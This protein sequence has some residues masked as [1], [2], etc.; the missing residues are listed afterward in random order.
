MNPEGLP[1]R[2]KIL[3]TH[4][5]NGLIIGGSYVLIA[6]GLTLIFGILDAIN[7]AHGEVYMLGAYVLYFLFGVW[8]LNYWAALILAT[9]II[10]IFGI[11]IEKLS[12][13]PLRNQ[14]LLNTMLVSIALAI[15]LQNLAM[16]FWGADP[17]VVK[18]AMSEEV[19]QVFGVF[20]TVQRLVVLIVGA[21]A[22]ILLHLLIEKTKIGKAMRAVAQDKDA[23]ALMG[24]SIDRVYTFTFA[25]GSALAAVAGALIAPIFQIFP[26]MGFV[27]F[28][29]AFTVVILGGLGNVI[30]AIYAGFILGV[31]ESLGAAYIST[32]YKD[33]FAFIILIIMLLLK[34]SGLMGRS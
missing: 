14:P 17:K 23:A 33:S 31:A 25:V 16:L 27:P 15:L 10:G 11:V 13:R 6:V 9:G 22:I 24:I 30:G 19:I 21:V 18:T 32:P 20:L 28:I 2:E 12:F 26:T 1:K 29:K 4:I 7:L 5:L 3:E 8:G 34:P